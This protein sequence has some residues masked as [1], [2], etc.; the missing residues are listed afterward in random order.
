M[1]P[2]TAGGA[3]EKHP[4]L[5]QL[6]HASSSGQSAAVRSGVRAARG[7]IVATLDGD[8]QNNPAFLPELISAVE[9]GGGRVGL[10]R[11]SGSDARTP[12]SRSCSRESPTACASQS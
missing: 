12:V 8:G 6:K 11:V 1:R 2:P 4:Q 5:R 3:D 7:A 9:S 10:A